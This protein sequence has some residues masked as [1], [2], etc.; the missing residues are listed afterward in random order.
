MDSTFE[1]AESHVEGV[2]SAGFRRA[3][4]WRFWGPQMDSMLANVVFLAERVAKL[5]KN[6]CVEP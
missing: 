5:C 1:K 2:C 6:G 3:V 4:N